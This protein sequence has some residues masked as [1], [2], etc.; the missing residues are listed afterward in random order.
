MH[1]GF[2]GAALEAQEQEHEEGQEPDVAAGLRPA[3]LLICCGDL[4]SI[5]AIAGDA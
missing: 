3:A 4:A 2:V 1:V 5:V